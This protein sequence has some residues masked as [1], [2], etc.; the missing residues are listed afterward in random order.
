MQ[1]VRLQTV[2]IL[3]GRSPGGW[4]WPGQFVTGR[5]TGVVQLPR[6]VEAHSR[7]RCALAGFRKKNDGDE[8]G[9]VAG[10]VAVGLGNMETGQ[11]LAG[12][13]HSFSCARDVSARGIA[14]ITRQAACDLEDRVLS[15]SNTPFAPGWVCQSASGHAVVKPGMKTTATEGVAIDYKVYSGG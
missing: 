7:T 1:R 14:A 13:G 11:H 2:V 9:S 5:P 15:L 8:N 3:N 12:Q 6:A 10:V 4:E